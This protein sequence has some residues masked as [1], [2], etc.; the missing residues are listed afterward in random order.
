MEETKEPRRH[1][2]LIWIEA[3][4]VVVFALYP[5]SMGPAIL[6]YDQ[7]AMSFRTFDT[8]YGP[9]FRVAE[10]TGSSHAIDVY[11]RWW[12]KITGRHSYPPQ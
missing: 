6:L 4:L 5:L 1:R 10:A 7:R 3:V 12:R 11:I 2:K 9:V 8:I